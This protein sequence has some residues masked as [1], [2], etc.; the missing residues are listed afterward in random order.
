MGQSKYKMDA[1]KKIIQFRVNQK[2]LDDIKS[3]IPDGYTRA[4]FLRNILL[5]IKIQDRKISTNYPKSDSNLICELSRISNYLN[6][7]ARVV[8]MNKS[9]LD[10]H[11]L[12]LI[13]SLRN[14]E[15]QLEYISNI[16]RYD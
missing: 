9:N 3:K 6:K 15:I 7:V 10:I 2:E 13:K 11:Y 8:N 1:R 16:N 12:L 4:E 5:Q 14:I